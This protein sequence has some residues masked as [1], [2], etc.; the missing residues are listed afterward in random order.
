ME[1]RHH[2]KNHPVEAALS[3]AAMGNPLSRPKAA[4]HLGNCSHLSAEVTRHVPALP[5]DTMRL[6]GPCHFVRDCRVVK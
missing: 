2:G 4:S 3:V 1:E 6:S 5:L